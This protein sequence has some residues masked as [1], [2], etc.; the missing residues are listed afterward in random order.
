MKYSAAAML[1]EKA[2]SLCVFSCCP[3][4]GDNMLSEAS[5]I[6]SI[7]R[8]GY[9]TCFEDSDVYGSASARQKKGRPA[10]KS[11]NGACRTNV[12]GDWRTRGSTAGTATSVRPGI[13]P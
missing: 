5:M 8:P 11:T 6:T 10:R 4:K 2:V 9:D 7:R 12:R 1:V 13:L 3:V